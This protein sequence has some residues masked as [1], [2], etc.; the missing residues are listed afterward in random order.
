MHWRKLFRLIPMLFLLF[1]TVPTSLA[2]GRLETDR[3]ME[4]DIVH[5][6]DHTVPGTFTV[7]VSKTQLNTAEE[8]A[9]IL[10]ASADEEWSVIFPEI[11]DALGKFRVVDRAIEGPKM[12]RNRNLIYTN[13]YTLEPFLPGEYAIPP[14]EVSFEDQWKIYS[15]PVVSEEIAVE[16]VTVLPPQLGEQDIEEILGPLSLPQRM[17]VWIGVA[18]PVLAAL[19]L[20]FMYA[21]RRFPVFRTEAVSQNVWDMALNELDRLL[22]KKLIEQGRYREFYD[23]ISDLT[24]HYVER[25]FSI[26][27]PEQTTEEFLHQVRN[28]NALSHYTPL[29]DEFLSTCDLVKFA[30][31]RPSPEVVEQTVLH[32]RNFLRGTAPQRMVS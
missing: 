30:K 6:Y 5:T 16:V 4:F 20:G 23:D 32:C 27:A 28:T 1:L 14:L 9:L 10:E 25:R 21:R 7:S 8:I 11:Q 31:L 2:R 15:I 19:V 13:R 12:D 26:R 18:V 17:I 29:L 24:R 22:G 3:G